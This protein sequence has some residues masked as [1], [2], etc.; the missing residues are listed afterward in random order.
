MKKQTLSIMFALLF[1]MALILGACAQPES[2]TI[3]IGINA[4]M[5]GD[6]PKVGEGTKF[7]A[8][9]WLEDVEKAGGLEVGGTKYPVEV[10]LEDNESKA[11]S[12]V[13]ANTKLI[14]QDD[15]LV[16]IGPH[17]SKQAIPA[18]DVAIK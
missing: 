10:I 12:A 3:V 5:T 14:T 8:E 15:V 13:K 16:I 11:E 6:I 7:A 4:P 9:M 18:G 2:E 17:S 1:V